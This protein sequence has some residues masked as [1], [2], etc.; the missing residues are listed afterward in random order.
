MEDHRMSEIVLDRE[1]LA[2]LKEATKSI[3]ITDEAGSV[4]GTFVP[5]AAF[6]RIMAFLLPEPT[7]EE[8]AEAR[9]EMLQHGGV[10]TA[11]LLTSLDDAKRK[12]EASQ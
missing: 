1:L 12:W 2:K 6:E 5:N 7:K 9:V 11:E 8:L 4:I 10:S 3:P